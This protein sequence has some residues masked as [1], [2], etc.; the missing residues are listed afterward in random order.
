MHSLPTDHPA[1][2]A[3]V[4]CYAGRSAITVEATSI[5]REDE[6]YCATLNL[7]V[8]PRLGESIQWQ[9]KITVQLAESELPL[10]AAVCLGYLPRADF[11]RPTKG[12]SIERQPNKLFVSATQGKG[13]AYALPIPIAETFQ[14]GSLAL[15]QLKKQGH[16]EEP[17]LLL[18]ALRGAA[19][20]FS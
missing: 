5:K 8:A 13:A 20:L 11:K 10:F 2:Q 12:I 17:E 7:D 9:K 16:V 4:R 18:A 3:K 19:A 15:T 6:R 1:K 14:M